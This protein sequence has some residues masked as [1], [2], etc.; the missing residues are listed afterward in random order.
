MGKEDDEYFARVLVDD[1]YVSQ[2]ERA[3][4]GIIGAAIWRVL[5]RGAVLASVLWIAAYGTEDVD[6]IKQDSFNYTVRIEWE[7]DMSIAAY[8]AAILGVAAVTA[9]VNAAQIEVSIPEAKD[10]R[11][12]SLAYSSDPLRSLDIALR[13]YHKENP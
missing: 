10:I 7:D 6:V 13:E 11:T 5:S 2:L 3:K 4:K 12:R 9:R 1:Y 8:G